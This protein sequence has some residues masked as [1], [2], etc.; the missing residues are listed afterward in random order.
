MPKW[1]FTTGGDVSAR[2]AVVNGVVYFPDWGGNLWALNRSNGKVIWS[3]Q[4]SDYLGAP[5]GSIH[6]RATAAISGGNLYI[7]TQEGAYLL[8]IKTSSGALNW[9]T[10]LGT[11]VYA[12]DTTSPVVYGNVVYT[13]LASVIEGGVAYG[14]TNMSQH[15]NARGS[16]V[17]LDTTSGTILWRTYTVPL[18]YIGG[19]VWGSN[20]VV[21]ASRNTLY[22]GTGNNYLEPTD[23]AYTS[24]IAGGGTR[25]SCQSP[26]NHADSIIALNMS[27]GA[28]KWAKRLETWN[29]T[30]PPYYSPVVDG[31]DFWNVDCAIGPYGFQCP[32]NPGPDYDF[33]SAPNE[34]TYTGSDHHTHT[35]IGAGQKSGIYYA[36]NPDT[37]ALLWNTQ[38]GP[39]SSLGGMEWGSASDGTRIYVQITNIYGIPYAA[40]NAGSWSALDPATGNILWQ[41]ADPNQSVALGPVTVANGVVYGESMA[42]NASAPTMLALDASNGNILWGYAAG[43]S[44]IGGATI[45]QDTVYWGSGYSHFGPFY[46]F[47]GNNKFFAFT[48]NGT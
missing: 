47:T 4:L 45:V 16:V 5:S 40:G 11:D 43:S 27:T 2:A 6:A 35:I 32:T 18:G 20:P 14:I 23:S 34:I 33:G 17:A 19:G 15:P 48:P 29:Q 42:A 8:S 38:V 1:T 41:R 37:G 44:V 31:S 9:A 26:D 22:V 46:P 25:D 7:G 39:G 13:G 3:H 36:L 21:D 30:S 12:I 10:P 28:V 24:C